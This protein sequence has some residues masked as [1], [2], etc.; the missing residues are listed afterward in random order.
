MVEVLA[1]LH[2]Y[3]PIKEYTNDVYISSINE[4]V[5]EHRAKVR[6]ILFGEDQ[7]TA[8]RARGAIKAM[9]N[10]TTPAKRLEGIIPVV[11]DWH[12]KMSFLDVIWK[13]FFNTWSARE[14]G[15]LY[16]LKNIINHTRVA[17]P[18]DDFN[19]CDDF[20][21]IVITGHILAAAMDMLGM[22]SLQDTPCHESI[23]SPETAWMESDQQRQK[24]LQ[25]ISM[26]IVKKI[27]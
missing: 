14:H 8:A 19:A 23:P 20:F 9:S 16:Q 22:E 10:A 4:T 26:C 3:V 15:T 2:Q 24:K 6:K 17:K 27:R 21:E 13:Y 7:L 11:E 18:K 25:E 12:A 5:V 1:H